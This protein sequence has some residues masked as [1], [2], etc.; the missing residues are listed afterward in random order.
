MNNEELRAQTRQSAPHIKI[1]AK[2][3]IVG[4]MII[5]GITVIWMSS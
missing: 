3:W 1:A 2:I 5:M 4:I